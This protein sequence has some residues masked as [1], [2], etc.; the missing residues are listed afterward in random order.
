MQF[1]IE[2]MKNRGD[3]DFIS[4]LMNFTG[5]AAVVAVGGISLAVIANCAL[6]ILGFPGAA[7]KIGTAIPIAIGVIGALGV[8]AGVGLFAWIVY[9]FMEALKS[10]RSKV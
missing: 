2:F 10:V 4:P 8:I 5:N 9:T 3:F 7:V 1:P 6:K